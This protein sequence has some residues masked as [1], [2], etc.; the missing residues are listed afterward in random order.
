[1]IETKVF[2]D[3]NKMNPIELMTLEANATAPLTD[4]K[5]KR[6]WF[7]KIFRFKKRV[8]STIEMHIIV[9]I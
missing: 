1:M 8:C 7:K 3:I 2:A 6:G 5:S 9:C 4:H